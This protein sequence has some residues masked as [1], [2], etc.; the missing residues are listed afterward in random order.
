MPDISEFK[1]TH[2]VD[3][4]KAICDAC[5]RLEIAIILAQA[6]SMEPAEGD[7][8][9]DLEQIERRTDHRRYDRPKQPR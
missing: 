5:D 7:K 3:R 6:E 9:A 2:G 8:H 4:K 1:C